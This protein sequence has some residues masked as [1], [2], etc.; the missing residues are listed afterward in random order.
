MNCPLC[1]K[2]AHSHGTQPN[3]I[4]RWKC[5][6]NSCDTITFNERYGTILYRTRLDEKDAYEL[7]F[8]FFT[9]YPIDRMAQLKHCTENKV[10][11]F[12]KKTVLGFE[13]F[14]EYSFMNSTY[15]PQAIE[16]D[17]IYIKLQ[18][19]KKFYAW[20]AFDP[21]NR[22]ILDFEIGKRDEESLDK[23]FSRMQKYRC[24]IKL[25]LIDGFK[26]YKKVVS[27]Y[28]GK[29]KFRPTTGVL[30]KSKYMKNQNGFLTYGLFGKTRDDV[31]QLILKYHVGKKI[32]TALI[33]R[34][35]RDFRDGSS[36]MARR[37]HRLPRIME[38]VNLAFKGIKAFHN[39]CKP[40]LTLSFKSS[41]NWISIP[42]TPFME[43]GILDSVVSIDSLLKSH[44]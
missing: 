22:I 17:E 9:G 31:E 12:L 4:A 13:K 2:K 5:N 15:Y 10:R 41:K 11:S 28:L 40:H 19:K 20:I 34:M 36:Y 32:S 1:N 3:G 25:V 24:K 6:N 21:I 8:L 39:I 29:K 23:I 30:N 44:I 42:I 14:E 16:V 18:G 37:T 7:A 43:A 33:E 27:K 35:N 38:W 26:P